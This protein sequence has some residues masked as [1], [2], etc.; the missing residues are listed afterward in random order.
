MYRHQGMC[1]RLLN[2]VET[3]CK[4][5]CF[6]HLFMRLKM[7][8]LHTDR[9]QSKHVYAKRGKMVW[10]RGELAKGNKESVKVAELSGVG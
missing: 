2:A 1:R 6:A 3:V 7:L 10:E 5:L 4:F 9:T 8:L